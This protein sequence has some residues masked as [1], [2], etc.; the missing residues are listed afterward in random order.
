MIYTVTLNPALDYMMRVDKLELDLVNRTDDVDLLPGG[1]G[2]I[3]SR[4]M[5]RLGVPSVAWGFVGGFSGKFV[6]DYLDED[7]VKTDFVQVEAKTRINVTIKDDDTET[8]I[9]DSGA[10][11]AAEK[12]EEFLAK[13]DALQPGDIVCLA[14]SIPKSL[15]EDFYEVLIKRIVARGAQF[16]IDVDQD[17]LLKALDDKP[18]VIKP[19]RQEISEL[20]EIDF[21]TNDDIIPYG[22]KMLEM[23]SQHVMVSMA[24]DGAL[25]FT[26]DEVYFAPPVTGFDVLNSVGAGD[27][28]VAGF[29]AEYSKSGDPV[30]AFKQGVACGS[31]K[32]FSEDMP[33]EA[34]I[35]KMFELVQ[36]KKIK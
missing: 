34:F 33:D 6:E 35:D 1:K 8:S 27:S 11:I 30:A 24:G 20:F 22:Q 23:G 2:I 7:G 28:T 9:N 16:A 19:N 21:E 5:R 31:A 25:L 36:I 12:V 14:G 26:G 32:V 13:F 4:M 10:P 18:I 3:E 15:G 29:I 17:K